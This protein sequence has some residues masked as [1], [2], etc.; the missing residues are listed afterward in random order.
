MLLRGLPRYL[1]S[2]SDNSLK[3]ASSLGVIHGNRTA[4]TLLSALHRFYV[5]SLGLKR[6]LIP[7]TFLEQTCVD[8]ASRDDL[9]ITAFTKVQKIRGVDWLKLLYP[10]AKTVEA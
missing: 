3:T 9:Y 1:V 7:G 5:E 2:D 6:V 10:Y 8:Y 4:D